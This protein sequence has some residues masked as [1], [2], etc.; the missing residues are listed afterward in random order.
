[1]AVAEAT[2]RFDRVQIDPTRLRVSPEEFA[3]AREAVGAGVRAALVAAVE[4]ARRFSEWLRPPAR[5]V[6][7]LEPGITVGVQFTPLASVGAYVPSGKG[8]FPSTVVTLLTP[9][10]VAGVPEIAVVVPPQP[11]GSADPAVLVAAELLGVDRVYRCNGP[12]GIAALAVGTES[13]PRVEALVGP[14][15]PYVVAMQLLAQ[16]RG[17]RVLGTFGPTE[18]VVLA[19]AEAD[20]D[21][22]AL[23][24]LN[25]AE[26]GSDSAALLVTPS[27]ELAH[28]VRARVRSLL[29][30]LPQP[31]REYAQAALTDLGGIFVVDGWEEAVAFVNLYAPEHVMVHARDPWAVAHR[32]Q[33]AGEIL[34]GPHTPFSAANYAIGVPAAL[35]TGGGARRES[36]VTV[37]SYLKVTSVA[38]LD[39]EGLEKVR[40]VVE[41]LGNYEG[42]PAH[43]MAVRDRP[44]GGVR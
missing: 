28:A 44:A 21:R 39:T 40:P 38:E 43:V 30:R 25:E 41:H 16:T 34:L 24:L 37:L 6:E 5:M 29:E 3:S 18:S 12:A 15:N 22:V 23:D 19:D 2:A 31:R 10:V 42:F 4:R 33:H 1:M 13:F 27:E 9:A 14:G 7:E 35:P 17:V 11:D 20:P 26:H 8:R 36:G 32:I